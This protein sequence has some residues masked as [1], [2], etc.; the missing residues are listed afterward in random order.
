MCKKTAQLRLNA[1]SASKEAAERVSIAAGKVPLDAHIAAEAE[2]QQEQCVTV[3]KAAC[4]ALASF[5]ASCRALAEAEARAVRAY[6]NVVFFFSNKQTQTKADQ[7]A[8]K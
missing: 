7:N 2:R 5:S 1:R 4:F 6:M 3:A 8:V